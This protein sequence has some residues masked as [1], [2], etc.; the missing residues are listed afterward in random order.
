M[1]L[2]V[3]EKND[4]FNLNLKSMIPQTELVMQEKQDKQGAE[5]WCCPMHCETYQTDHLLPGLPAQRQ[6]STMC[7][8]V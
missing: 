6:L 4:K 7:A 2:S 8:D 3:T 5:G 1:G